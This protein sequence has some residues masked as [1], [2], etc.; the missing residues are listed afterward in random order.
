M[1]HVHDLYNQH[2]DLSDAAQK[3]AG[4]AIGGAMRR[5]HEDYMM[6]L[7]GLVDRGEIDLMDP[8][9]LL[10]FTVYDRLSDAAKGKIDQA[11]VN[12]LHEVRRI[13]EFYK[14]TETP[15]ASPHLETMVEHAWQM[16][17]RLETQED[18]F[19]C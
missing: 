19:K 16:V 17:K 14:S 8:D 11:K 13:V 18:V 10:N 15:N 5:E 9:S 3:Q 2:K 6:K 1:T 12:L 4:Q 7:V